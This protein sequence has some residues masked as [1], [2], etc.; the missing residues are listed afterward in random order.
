MTVGQLISELCR[1][2]DHATINFRCPLQRQEL[3]FLRIESHSTGD[4]EIELD[5]VHKATSAIPAKAQDQ[6]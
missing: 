1:Y 6:P 3:R 2:P 4:L 5:P